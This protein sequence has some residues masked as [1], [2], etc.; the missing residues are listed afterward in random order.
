MVFIVLRDGFISMRWVWFL[1]NLGVSVCLFLLI[2]LV[3]GV[4]IVLVDIVLIRL[5][6]IRMLVFLICC[7]FM[8]LKIW[9]LVNR[10]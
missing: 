7:L 3:F 8:L 6:F 4:L 9:I 2:I 1:M 10:V 5:F